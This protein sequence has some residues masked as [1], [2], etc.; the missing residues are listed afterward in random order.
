MTN[1]ELLEK[2]PPARF[3]DIGL[4]AGRHTKLAAE[5]GFRAFGM[6]ISFV[7]LQHA[8][9]RL[10]TAGLDA[11][12][13]QAS[14]LDLP[15]SE[16]SFAAVLSFGVFYYGTEKEMK[17]AIAE[18]HRVLIPGGKAF[19]VTRTAGDY[20]FG[21]GTRL[22]RNTFELDIDDTNEYGSVQHFLA[23]DDVPLYFSEFAHAASRKPKQH[24]AIAVA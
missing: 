14:M 20:R 18:V 13:A 16:C 8:R 11:R 5:L 6:D 15:F 1:R 9:E 19:L 17:Q 12:L 21:K 7:G 24:S 23:S 3:L 22:G 2:H 4:G 10:L